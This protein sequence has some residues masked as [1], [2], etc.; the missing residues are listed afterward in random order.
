MPYKSEAQRR[1]M[2]AVLHDPAVAKKTGI[3]KSVAQDFHQASKGSGKKLPE[4][5][6]KR[7]MRRHSEHW[8]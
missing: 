8:S 2:E 3:S 7:K 1:L 4:R 6:G 5:K